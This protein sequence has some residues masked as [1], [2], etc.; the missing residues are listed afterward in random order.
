MK[1]QGN[2]TE[3]GEQEFTDEY[4]REKLTKEQYRVLREKGT[5]RPFSG[6]YW[7]HKE[8]GVYHCQACG[9]Q[10]FESSGKFDS[11][12]G[13]P[14]FDRSLKKEAIAEKIDTTHNMHRTEVLC[15]RCNSHLGHVFD[16]GPTETGTR[17]CINSVSLGFKPAPK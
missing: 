14:A 4:F 6:T 17:Y 12:C 5:E 2:S 16:D 7:N 10:L 8:D 1:K 13:W 11:A 9:Q 15:S 3:S